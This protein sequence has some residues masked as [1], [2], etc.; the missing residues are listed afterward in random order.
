MGLF[1]LASKQDEKFNGLV[2][3]GA[4]GRVQAPCLGDLPVGG[5]ESG[6]QRTVGAPGEGAAS[7][8]GLC[9]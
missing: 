9:G 2:A 7:A 3:A 4:T 1:S 6:L 8:G 5:G